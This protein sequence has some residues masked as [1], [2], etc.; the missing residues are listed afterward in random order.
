VS[1]RS[2]AEVYEELF[3]PALF[4][5][6]GRVVAG[7]AGVGPGQRV[8][9]VA[10]GT[11]VLALAAAELVGRQGAVVGLDCNP[12]ML[13]VAR[14]KSD[15][16]EWREGRA[17]ALPFPHASFDVAASQFGLM[18]FEDRPLALREMMRVLRP[19]GR[20][21]VAVCDA[22][23]RSPGYAALA[24]LLERLFG[25]RIAN[26][27]RAPFALGDERVLLSLCAEAGIAGASVR[28]HDGTVRFASINAMISTER[29]CVMTLGGL[30][31]DRQFARLLDEAQSALAPFAG[32]GGK[33]AFQMPALIITAV[34]A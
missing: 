12:D 33:V 29:A 4:Q 31:D 16:A 25:E 7:A 18:F 26:A 14:R 15:R 17:E 21:A 3:V 5:Q 6:W 11:G 13:R 32:D 27:F 2:P 30:L 34:R 20:L 22:L 8:L 28:R 9:D 19:G 23:E 10:C 24:A 1:V